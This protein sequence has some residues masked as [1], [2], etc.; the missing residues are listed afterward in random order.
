MWDAF[1]LR[2]MR[3]K[4]NSRQ[5]CEKAEDR[6]E[7]CSESVIREQIPNEWSR[8]KVSKSDSCA[9]T[10][11]LERRKDGRKLERDDLWRYSSLGA[12]R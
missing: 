11:Q 2:E 7:R 6:R 3:S 9:S 8:R 12:E 5:Q 4:K 10:T 1:L